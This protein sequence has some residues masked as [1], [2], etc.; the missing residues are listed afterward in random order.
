MLRGAFHPP[1]DAEDH[2]SRDQRH[3]GDAVADGVADLHLPEELALS[4]QQRQDH[5][6]MTRQ[7]PPNQKSSIRGL[8]WEQPSSSITAL[9]F[10]VSV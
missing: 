5:M 1:E 7:P 3:E 2:D 9:P 6:L 10:R 4:K 8:N